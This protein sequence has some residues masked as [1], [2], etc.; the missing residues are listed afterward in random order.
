MLLGWDTFKKQRLF[1]KMSMATNEIREMK[2]LH[3]K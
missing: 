2:Q 1:E 3:E